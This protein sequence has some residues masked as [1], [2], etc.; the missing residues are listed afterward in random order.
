MSVRIGK[1]E[2]RATRGLRSGETR[3][4][5][6][7][8]SPGQ[9]GAVAQELGS[10]PTWFVVE[11]ALF[12]PDAAADLETLRAAWQKGEPQA[13]AAEIASGTTVTEVVIE[14]L[15]VD[16]RAGTK[17][18]FDLVL[19]LRE[20]T[21]PPEKKGAG[22]AAVGGGVM[23]DAGRWMK[24]AGAVLR[25]VQDPSRL[26]AELLEHP[27]LLELLGMDELADAILDQLDE[28]LPEELSGAL[29][30]VRT[31]DPRKAYELAEK[32][33]TSDS[34]EDFVRKG[35]LGAVQELGRSLGLD[36]NALPPWARDLTGVAA[37]GIALAA[38]PNLI[39]DLQ[40]LTRS[41]QK[42]ARALAK[43]DA[44]LPGGAP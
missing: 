18:R 44:L 15:A 21:A 7:Q 33:A 13:L 29:R 37:A 40:K 9:Q 3:R 31:L 25:V 16:Q 34:F 27:E 41:A 38:D 4:R 2:L 39:D 35:G 23:K 30:A 20:H 8:G 28:L 1:V 22:L 11:G 36:P 14:D 12:G 24:V 32:I 43:P 5:V 17:D 6:V 19:R 42:L 26:G 10:E